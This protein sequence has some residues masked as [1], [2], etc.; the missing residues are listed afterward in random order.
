MVTRSDIGKRV[1][2]GHRTGVLKDVIKDWED[3]GKIRSEAFK[4]TTAFVR[5]EGGGREWMARPA[6]LRCA[7]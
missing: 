7:D 5:P 4:V 3:P 1:T 2:D 6:N